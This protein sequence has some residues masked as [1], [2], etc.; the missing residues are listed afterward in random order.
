M[1]RR[2]FS[3]GVFFTVLVSNRI[4]IFYFEDFLCSVFSSFFFHCVCEC[5]NDEKIVENLHATTTTNSKSRIIVLFW[6]VPLFIFYFLPFISFGELFC[7]FAFIVFSVSSSI[8]FFFLFWCL[9]LFYKTSANVETC[10]YSFR[11]P[12]ELTDYMHI[13]II[14]SWNSLQYHYIYTSYT[15]QKAAASKKNIVT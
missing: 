6:Y 5:Q 15:I 7:S 11:L 12:L 13:A 1:E 10:I 2:F 3:F 4:Y 9:V 8:S 14:S